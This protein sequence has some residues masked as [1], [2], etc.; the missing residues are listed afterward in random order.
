MFELSSYNIKTKIYKLNVNKCVADLLIK[1]VF[2]Y[3]FS[4]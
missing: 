4:L 2:K 1:Y 3:N